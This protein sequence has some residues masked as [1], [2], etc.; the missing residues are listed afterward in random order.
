MKSQRRHIS[1]ELS[2]S[3]IVH[4][5][6][7][8]P[9]W[10][11]SDQELLSFIKQCIEIGVTTFDHADI[12]GNYSCEEIFGHAIKLD[13]SVSKN[14]EIVTKCGIKLLSDKYPERSI[15]H[16]DYSFEHIVRSAENSLKKLQIEKIDVFLLHRPAPFFNPEEV[17][18]AFDNLHK[19]GKV[20]HF[21]VSNFTPLQFQSLQSHLDQKLL[22]NQVELSPYNLEHFR[23]G[24]IDFLLNEG[25][26]PMSWSPLA[27]GSIFNPQNEKA[28]RLSKVLNEVASELDVINIDSVIYSWLLKHPT[29]IA[30]IVGS[31]K[32]ERIKTAVQAEQVEMSLEQW[33]KIWVASTGHRVP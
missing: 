32:L 33:Y 28:H 15:K 20:L 1:N 18:K 26:T 14:I 19:S 5:E 3:R 23:N 25:I 29:Q 17:A 8:L 12:Y 7:R 9:E 10:N 22:I 2:I 27:G 16:Y 4:G 31:G 30:P 6:M 21:G 13:T 24:N 11:L